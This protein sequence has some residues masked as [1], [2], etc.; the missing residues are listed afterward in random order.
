MVIAVVWILMMSTTVYFWLSDENRKVIEAQWCVYTLWGEMTNYVFYALTSK[1][2]RTE[3]DDIVFPLLYAIQLTWSDWICTWAV[4]SG[5]NHCDKISFLYSWQNST[6]Y[7]LYHIYSAWNNCRWNN[8]KL[9][10]YRSWDNDIEYVEM[11]KWFMP[12]SESDRKVFY[13]KNN[14]WDDPIFWDIIVGLCLNSDCSSPKE[15]SKWVVDGRAQTISTRNCK[16]Y[17]SSDPTRCKE[18]EL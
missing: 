3:D 14:W 15:I 9:S 7:E 5:W 6:G 4:R 1:N 16:F 18:R 2:L 13:L 8:A 12:T 17:D 11:K 10:F